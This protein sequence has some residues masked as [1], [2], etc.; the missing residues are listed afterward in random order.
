MSFEG[1]VQLHN[2]GVIQTGTNV[3]LILDYVFLLGAADE[4]LQHYLHRIEIAVP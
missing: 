2:E 3:F 4:L 1:V